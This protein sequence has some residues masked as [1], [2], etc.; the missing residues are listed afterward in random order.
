MIKLCFF[1]VFFVM[2]TFALGTQAAFVP[3]FLVYLFV[4]VIAEL[5]GITVLRLR[6]MATFTL[7]AGFLMRTFQFEICFFVVESLRVER[8][9]PGFAPFMFC[10]AIAT[11][12]VFEPTMQACLVCYITRHILVAIKTQL[13]L[14]AFVELLVA[15][16]AF[17]L[18]FCMTCDYVTRHQRTLNIL[19]SSRRRRP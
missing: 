4:A 13:D 17:V 8:N 5:G 9:D 15:L 3:F 18:V 11:G 14:R 12:I 2:A 10:M 16:L 6:V 7:A 19:S 1:P